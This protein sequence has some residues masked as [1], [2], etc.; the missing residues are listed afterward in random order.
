MAAAA[1]EVLNKRHL[2]LPVAS[3]KPGLN[4]IDVEAVT[5]TG[6]DAKCD[7]VALTDQRERFILS[8]SSE[9]TVPALARVGT[10]PNISSILSGGLTQLSAS[11]EV[12][13]FVPKARIQALDASL[14]LLAKMASISQRETRA[15]FTFDRLVDGTRHVLAVGAFADMPEA[16]LR[17]ANLD[18][19]QLRQ[20]WQRSAP[21]T[22]RISMIDQPIQVASIG[23][24]AEILRARLGQPAKTETGPSS[25]PP[26]APSASLSSQAANA[27]WFGGSLQGLPGRLLGMAAEPMI[28]AGL[29][30]SR[31]GGDLIVTDQTTLV[32]A[33]GAKTKDLEADWRARLLPSVG[34]T[35]VVLAPTADQLLAGTSE[36]LSGSLWEQ[37]VGQ[38][39][40][41]NSREGA[42]ATRV[43]GEIWLVPTAPL[44]FQNGRLIAAGWLSRNV[45]VH[46]AALLGILVVLTLSLHRVLRM[47]GVREP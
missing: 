17:A 9:I 18:P 23:D 40:A 47:S 10:L 38:A 11:H 3:F 24:Q 42:V 25:A 21:E 31:D 14:T 44:D 28:R 19:G 6:N 46:L 41:Y 16:T 39:A 26:G 45:S 5:P 4:T 32:V 7:L 27:S 20:A 29:I 35:T 34:S 33:Q 12:Q 1:G 22:S 15:A 13:V 2:Y 37:F 43:S 36:L 8:G 30:K